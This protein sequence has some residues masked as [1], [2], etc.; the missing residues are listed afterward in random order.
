MTG[1]AADQS[2]VLRLESET[3]SDGGTPLGTRKAGGSS[4]RGVGIDRNRSRIAQASAAMPPITAKVFKMR[5]TGARVPALAVG[6][7]RDLIVEA[8][9]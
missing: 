6:S 3:F 5:F 2:R 7:T 8:G 1:F 4:S 9:S